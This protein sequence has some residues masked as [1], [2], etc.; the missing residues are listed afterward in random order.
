MSGSY[1]TAEFFLH[2]CVAL[3]AVGL[4]L[5]SLQLQF[6]RVA[7]SDVGL[8]PWPII[9]LRFRRSRFRLVRWMGS[10][11]FPESILYRVLLLHSTT[12]L[13]LLYTSLANHSLIAPLGCL[14]FLNITIAVRLPYGANQADSLLRIIVVAALLGESLPSSHGQEAAL[15]FICGQSLLAYFSSGVW[16]LRH[17]GWYDGSYVRELFA[18]RMFGTSYLAEILKRSPGISTSIGIG[19][20][21]CEVCCPL[22]VVLPENAMIVAL[23]LG[24]TFHFIAA[25]IMGLNTFLW[26][27]LATYPAIVFCHALV[28]HQLSL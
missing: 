17:T 19:V 27:F 24:V 23:L 10:L 3:A 22:I 15:M 11:P 20:V 9:R 21:I 26:A 18:T 25:I 4:V 14:V 6:S 5:T 12:A 7:T 8:M 1:I 16:K 2:A 13:W 28:H